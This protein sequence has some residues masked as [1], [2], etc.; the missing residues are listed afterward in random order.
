[1]SFFIGIAACIA[2][3]IGGNLVKNSYFIPFLLGLIMSSC[4][5]FYIKIYLK[6]TLDVKSKKR[7]LAHYKLNKMLPIFTNK[8]IILLMGLLV[9]D[10]LYWGTY[11]NFMPV[12]CKAVFNFDSVAVGLFLS[13]LGVYLMISTGGILPVLQKKISNKKITSIACLSLLCSSILL[14][15]ALIFPMAPFAIVFVWSSGFLAAFGDVTIFC[16]ILY[17]HQA[18]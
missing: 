3:I 16:N 1:M 18:M 12:L 14:F 11:Y 15:L 7:V 13:L 10:Q 5:Y 6:E 4:V 17:W 2:P 8:K 9:F